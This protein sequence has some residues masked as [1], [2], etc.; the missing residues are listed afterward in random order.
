MYAAE[1]AFREANPQVDMTLNT[2][3]IDPKNPRN[4]IERDDGLVPLP[5]G[6]F[7]SPEFPLEHKATCKW[8]QP[9][10]AKVT[11]MSIYPKVHELRFINGMYGLL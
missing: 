8:I 6:R 7:G 1:K 5:D 11:E 4:K 10:I 3:D 9:G 2:W